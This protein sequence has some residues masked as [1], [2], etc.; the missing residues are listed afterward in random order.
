METSAVYSTCLMYCAAKVP[1]GI[2]FV[3]MR[4]RATDTI[5]T[6][7]FE[8]LHHVSQHTN[9]TKLFPLS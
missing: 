3:P 7:C 6:K 8:V 4:S 5:R 2:P 9:Q 1:F